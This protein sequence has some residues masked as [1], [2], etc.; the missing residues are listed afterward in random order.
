MK[1]ISTLKMASMES[2]TMRHPLRTV[3]AHGLSV[4]NI[5]PKPSHWT[6]KLSRVLRSRS[7]LDSYATAVSIVPMDATAATPP[8]WG[9]NLKMRCVSLR[10]SRILNLKLEINPVT[11]PCILEITCGDAEAPFA[12][13]ESPDKILV[14]GIFSTLRNCERNGPVNKTVSL[15]CWTTFVVPIM[16]GLILSYPS[17]FE[18]KSPIFAMVLAP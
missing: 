5:F 15:I 4:F 3:W 13:E 8:V 6:R 11:I 9:A 16:L 2:G 12:T 18:N 1:I 10:N 7:L 17:K 14:L